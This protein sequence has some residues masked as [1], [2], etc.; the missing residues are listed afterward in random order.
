MRRGPASARVGRSL[1]FG[2]HDQVSLSVL[3]RHGKERVDAFEGRLWVERLAI[4]DSGGG[5][6]NAQV[7]ALFWSEV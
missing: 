7:V 2:T 3:S 4:Y 5:N 6:A 1:A